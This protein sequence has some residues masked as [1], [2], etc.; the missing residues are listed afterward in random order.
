[1]DIVTDPTELWNSEEIGLSGR[2]KERVP[3]LR[4]WLR[5]NKTLPLA[6]ELADVA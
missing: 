6:L 3:K 1:L 5:T 2:Q 4:D